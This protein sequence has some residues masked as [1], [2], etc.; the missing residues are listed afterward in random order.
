M[1]LKDIVHFRN[2][3][4][5][6]EPNP[7]CH[8]AIDHLR[9]LIHQVDGQDIRLPNRVEDL[10]AHLSTVESGV[11][12]FMEVV[13]DMDR[14]LMTLVQALEPAMLENSRE[15]HRMQPLTDKSDRMLQRQL[16]MD[17]VDR[18]RLVG[19]INN[20]ADWRM[21][22]MILRPGLESFVDI[23][24]GWDPLYVVDERSELLDPCVTK[25]NPEYQRRLRKYT[26]NDHGAAPYLKDLPDNQFGLILAYNYFNY[27]PLEVVKQYLSEIAVKLRP[28]GEA[29]VTY[30]D[31][32]WAHGV[33]LAE[34]AFMSYVPGRY[35]IE[36]ARG[37][38]LI[39]STQH[40]GTGDVCWLVLK[41]PGEM[42]SIRGGQSLA[43]ILA[44]PK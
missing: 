41:K 28:G 30:N 23:M 22:A 32:D 26:V 12:N 31:C 5:K 16:T 43:K 15:V 18:D 14:Q 44:R 3:L 2:L 11:N 25:F 4:A 24:V 21:P 20:I 29:I 42:H 17:D 35:L 1:K 6:F 36:H 40:R 19:K 10:M 9:S 27:K 34:Q 8:V 39:V 33:A 13:R 38:G 7:R 37:I